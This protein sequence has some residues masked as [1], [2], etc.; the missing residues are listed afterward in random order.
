MNGTLSRRNLIVGSAAA[1]TLV[2]SPHIV[3]AAGPI[4]LRVSSSAP[5]DRFGAHYL[6]Y[7]PFEEELTKLAGDRI[8]LEYFPNGQLG[9]EADVV[10]Q[11]KVGAV[12]M[13][14]TGSSIWAT[15]VPEFGML[16]L[17][18]LFNSY[19]HCAKA[20]DTGVGD[21]YNKLLLERS[22]V[23]IL[24][25]TFQVGARSIYTKTPVASVSALKGVK[26]RVL[27]NKSFIDTFNVI[28][29]TPTPIPMN[30][31]YMAVQTGVVDGFEHDPGTVLAYKL[32]E[33]TKYC[34]LTRH[35]YTPLLAYIGRSGLAKIPSDLRPL[36]MQAA[37]HATSVSRNEVKD[38][39]AEALADLKAK[40]IVFTE[41]PPAD[42]EDLKR[43]MADT[44][45]TAYLKQ[46]PATE[47]LFA[48]IKA[49]AS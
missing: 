16:D 14:L 24:G 10:N 25:W 12:D 2:C 4:R 31:V 42:I 15:V 22:G 11:V 27:P 17:G 3:R 48:Q 47:P 26:L 18:F 19:D 21:A 38:V 44:L 7:K 6:W 37:A 28:G 34:F 39:E 43:K 49:A 1:A 33:V 8:K 32:F 35:I 41:A 40:D 45:Y 23:T 5:P 13:M 9:K 30:E 29:A 36:L 20:L 46:Y